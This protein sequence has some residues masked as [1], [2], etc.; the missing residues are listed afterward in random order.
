MRSSK[1]KAARNAATW[2]MVWLALGLICGTPR[3]QAEEAPQPLQLEV[4]INN[5]AIKMVGSFVRFPDNRI[6]ATP[7]ELQQLGLRVADNRDPGRIVLLDDIPTL[8]YEYLERSQTLKISVADTYRRAQAFDLNGQAQRSAGRARADWGAV[9]NYDFLASSNGF[10][11]PLASYNRSL[12]VDGRAFSPYGTF[13][14]SA[15]LRGS[16]GDTADI[17][18]L[19]TS[20]RYSDDERM[21]TYTAGDAISSGLAWSRPIRMGG[22]QAQSNFALR[23]DLITMPLPSMAGTAA[24]PSTVDIY[25]NN[26][27]T[28]SRQ[29]EA[30]PFS[31]NNVPLISGGGNAQLVIRNSAGH[32]VQSN[33]PFYASPSLLAPELMA[34]SV[35]AG[36][37]RLSYGSGSDI[38]VGSPVGSATLRRGIFDWL[39]VEAH[40]EGGAGIANAGAGAVIKT[41]NFGVAGVALAGSTG[42][43]GGGLQS[44]LSY[45]TSLFGFNFSASTQ[46][47]FGS[48]TD[49]ASATA[50]FQSASLTSQQYSGFFNFLPLAA[51][52]PPPLPTISAYAPIYTD[53]EPPRAIDRMT[54]SLPLRFDPCASVS[55]S[56]I[57]LEDSSGV[58]SDILSVSYTRS[59]PFGVSLFATAF[60]AR[61]PARN[62]GLFAGLSL[63]L[64]R[65]ASATTSVSAS[66]GNTAMVAD[67]AKSIGVEPGSYGWHIRDAEGTAV[68]R[69][70]SASY[71]SNFGAVQVGAS[72]N[73]SNS[74]A[75]LELRGSIVT[76]DRSVFLSNWIDDSFAV[77]DVGA[78]GITVLSENRPVGTTN[79]KG[80]L[81]V[82]TLRG[83][84]G[85]K[86]TVDPV[87]L[88][89][90]AEIDTTRE[91]VAPADRAGVLVR[92][93][94]R[95]DATAALVTFAGS[96]GRLIQAG[97]VG[98]LDNGQEFVVGYDGQ[99]YIRG[100]EASN[101]ASIEMRTGRCDAAFPFS[102]A[103]GEQ[104]HIGPVSCR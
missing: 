101:R 10:Q 25:V 79:A 21:I 5:V 57:H 51:L 69:Q 6:G 16:L 47:S 42:G 87:N 23:P 90:D 66:R 15:I 3:P 26:V 82:P 20:F 4:L 67:A 28:F 33:I 72:Q 97:S 76:M 92:F 17:L 56:F 96:D 54:I 36:L 99:A 46:R 40:A 63:P 81:L 73:S 93:Q 29:V 37:P 45:E 30:G 60:D 12:L 38:Y 103:P 89:V 43:R 52:T 2:C 22:F 18:R 39:T 53:F 31:I 27:K 104:A 94:T 84:Q 50:R 86:I 95:S 24:V 41:G 74:S 83:Y 68:D 55:G 1:S 77:V 64:G 49:L 71:R 80:L 65:S 48:Y 8:K 59:L 88:P 34:W 85:N 62:I 75:A 13:S 102:P 58:T 7:T 9:L 70:A 78:P 32:E 98:R 11:G 14:Q 44:Y 35:E 19:D 61:G 100:L 91:I